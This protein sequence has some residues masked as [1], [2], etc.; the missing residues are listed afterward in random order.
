MKELLQ[1]VVEAQY[2]FLDVDVGRRHMAEHESKRV[3]V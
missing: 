1:D 3:K 2:F